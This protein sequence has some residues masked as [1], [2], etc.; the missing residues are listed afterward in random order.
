MRLW[1]RCRWDNAGWGSAGRFLQNELWFCT[2][3]VYTGGV[4]RRNRLSH[5]LQ[6][7]LCGGGHGFFPGEHG[8]AQGLEFQEQVHVRVEGFR[9]PLL[10]EGEV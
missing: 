10:V 4:D 7:E 9:Q 2:E 1:N 8:L 6:N 3:G 5:L